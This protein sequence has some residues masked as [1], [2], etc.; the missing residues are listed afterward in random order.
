MESLKKSR[1]SK[2]EKYNKLR[3][4]MTYPN[5]EVTLNAIELYS[6]TCKV[7]QKKFF[8]F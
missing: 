1:H 2:S 3:N 7:F 5:N 8:F 4:L 6:M